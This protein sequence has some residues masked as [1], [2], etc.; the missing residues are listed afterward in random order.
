M[1]DEE[2][3]DMVESGD[4]KIFT[5]GVFYYL[6][7]FG[8]F[9]H[10]KSFNE[11]NKIKILNETKMARKTLED[12]EVRHKEILKLEKSLKELHSMFIDLA[13]LINSQ[14]IQLLEPFNS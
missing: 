9:L 14:V 11:L 1:T 12:I 8:F 6:I 10:F 3:H 13:Q 2:I 7:L 4:T 5:Y